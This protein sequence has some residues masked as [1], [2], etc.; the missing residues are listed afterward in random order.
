MEDA[1]LLQRYAS[2]RS[3]EAFTELVRRHLPLVYSAALRRLGGSTHGAEDIAQCVFSVLAQQA[4]RLTDHVTLEGWLYTTTRNISLQYLRSQRRRMQREREAMMDQHAEDSPRESDTVRLRTLIDSALDRLATRDREVLLLRFFRN[5]SFGEIGAALRISENAARFRLNRAL[6][7]L[8]TSLAKHG[9]ASTAAAVAF[10][11]TESAQAAGTDAL[12]R[13][14]SAGALAKAPTIS[15][16]AVLTNTLHLM[17]TTKVAA[18]A[19]VVIVA[20]GSVWVHRRYTALRAVQAELAQS[21]RTHEPLARELSAAEA[22]RHQAATAAALATSTSIS[23]DTTKTRAAPTSPNTGRSQL[24]AHASAAK[25]ADAQVNWTLSR[26]PKIRALLSAWIKSCFSG[27]A[28]FYRAA[29][30]TPQQIEA[31]ENLSLEQNINMG[32]D[33]VLTLRPE[34]KSIAQV[35]QEIQSVLGENGYQQWQEYKKIQFVDA[36]TK[37]LAGFVYDSDS[38]LTPEQATRLTQIFVASSP[39]PMWPGTPFPKDIDWNLA[40]PA[41]QQIL[42]PTQYN[43]LKEVAVVVKYAPAGLNPASP[44]TYGDGVNPPAVLYLIGKR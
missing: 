43:A 22:V 7:R 10:V 30:L 8:R 29:N 35:D 5:R 2:T 21:I 6:E 18:V 3:N 34:G 12:V 28:S 11:L 14:V 33:S 17:T 37:G 39:N 15:T 32:P 20:V 42:T 27:Y 38:P 31:F 13:T 25:T 36:V 41:A 40:L 23:P 44:R 1:D 9:I 19:A 24:A 26:D 4:D 16:T